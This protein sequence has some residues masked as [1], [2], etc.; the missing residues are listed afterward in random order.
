MICKVLRS[1]LSAEGIDEFVRIFKE[2]RFPLVSKRKGFKGTCLFA[3]QNGEFMEVTFWEQEEQ[4]I[5][6]WDSP[7]RNKLSEQA[8]HLPPAGPFT[9]VTHD[10]FE[11]RYISSLEV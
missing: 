9:S 1:Q 10:V 8:K 5:A 6:W 11:V 3:K 2:Q 4:A 7:E